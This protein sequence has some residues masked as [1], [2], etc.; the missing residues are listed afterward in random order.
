M[1]AGQVKR[2][3]KA[4]TIILTL[5]AIFSYV[6][7]AFMGAGAKVWNPHALWY[8]LGFAALIFPV[9]AF[10]HYVQ[11]GGKFPVRMLEDLG[12]TDAH[13]LGE[14]RAGVLPYLT[15]AGG[16]A[17]VLIANWIFTL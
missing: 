8:G 16:I 15:L 10:R 13:A 6:N 3:Y 14:R 2:P 4:P 9:F 1:D 17:V 5:G 7:A 11:D 12:V